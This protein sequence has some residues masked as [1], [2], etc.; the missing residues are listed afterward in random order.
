M[1]IAN[2]T[3]AMMLVLPEQLSKTQRPLVYN[4]IRHLLVKLYFDCV[5]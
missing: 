3:D 2:I 1:P 4:L 5:S